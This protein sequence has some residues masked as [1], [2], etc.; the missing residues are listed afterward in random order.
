M[1]NCHPVWNT[2]FIHVTTKLSP[3]SVG[4]MEAVQELAVYPGHVTAEEGYLN[5]AQAA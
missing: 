3:V 4:D 5:L 1:C 2:P